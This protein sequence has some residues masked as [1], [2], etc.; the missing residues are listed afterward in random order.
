MAEG[1]EAE[2]ANKCTNSP[3]SKS[4]TVVKFKDGSQAPNEYEDV[5]LLTCTTLSLRRRAYCSP[6]CPVH[7]GPSL[8]K[9]RAGKATI[10]RKAHIIYDAP[11]RQRVYKAEKQ[12]PS[13]IDVISTVF[14]QDGDLIRQQ[15]SGAITLYFPYS[16]LL[17]GNDNS[18]ARHEARE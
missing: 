4:L 15:R 2:T 1:K 18:C 6:C 13:G 16:F 5:F 17:F 10:M 3:T 9:G 14:Y 8:T 11:A 12:N 7:S